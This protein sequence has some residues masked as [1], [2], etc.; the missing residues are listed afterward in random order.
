MSGEDAR[1]SWAIDQRDPKPGWG[2]KTRQGE[3]GEAKVYQAE[4]E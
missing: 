1:S 2:G 4:E 3:D